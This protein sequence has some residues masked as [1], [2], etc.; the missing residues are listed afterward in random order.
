[1]RQMWNACDCSV[2]YCASSWISVMSVSVEGRK[3]LTPC[4][5]TYGVN[6][7]LFLSELHSFC[8]VHVQYVCAQLYK[9]ICL[10]R[11]FAYSCLSLF[12]IC[13][14]RLS[15]LL[16]KS[17]LKRLVPSSAKVRCLS[18]SCNLHHYNQGQTQDHGEKKLGG[19]VEGEGR[20]EQGN[21]R[22]MA[23]E[24]GD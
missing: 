16:A 1:M 22:K 13:R 20:K 10:Q 9:S 15:A 4:Y 18:A 3:A 21:T 5:T 7:I 8:L 12:S 2:I 24:E 11:G 23:G 19:R 17:N 6:S 14:C